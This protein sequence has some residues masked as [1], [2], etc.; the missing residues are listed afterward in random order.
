L[1][2]IVAGLAALALGFAIA[3]DLRSRRPL[4]AANG[5]LETQPV[6]NERS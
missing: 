6:R 1:A 3:S 4:P 2:W 5:T